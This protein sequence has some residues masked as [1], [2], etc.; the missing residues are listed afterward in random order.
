MTLHVS[1]SHPP[2]TDLLAHAR[3]VDAA[4]AEAGFPWAHVIVNH[5]AVAVVSHLDGEAGPY[6]PSKATID[7]AFAV[8]AVGCVC[9][10]PKT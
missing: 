5:L 4:L 2:D 9:S 8:T 3:A 10:P 1:T 7:R 6:T